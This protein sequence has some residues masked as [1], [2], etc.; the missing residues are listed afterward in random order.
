MRVRTKGTH[1]NGVRTRKY[2]YAMRQQENIREISAWL[3]RVCRMPFSPF[4]LKVGAA[5]SLVETAYRGISGS[6]IRIEL[7]RTRIDTC[8]QKSRQI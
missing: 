2:D 8:V 5:K 6:G 4:C 7:W 3:P 1:L